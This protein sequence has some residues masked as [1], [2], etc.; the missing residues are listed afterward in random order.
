MIGITV[1]DDESMENAEVPPSQKKKPLAITLTDESL[2]NAEAPPPSQKPLATTLAKRDWSFS[3]AEAPPPSQKRPWARTIVITDDESLD[4]I[5][6]PP[7]QKRKALE[8]DAD[9]SQN[10]LIE[11]EHEDAASNVNHDGSIAV[12]ARTTTQVNIQILIHT[13]PLRSHMPCH[14]LQF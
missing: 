13:L 9:P 10:G 6:A 11:D 8:P 12:S 1:M 3:N 4:S 5:E 7:S 2:G 14:V